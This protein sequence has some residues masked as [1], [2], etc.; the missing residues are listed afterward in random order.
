[1]RITHAD[2]WRNRPSERNSFVS[3]QAHLSFPFLRRKKVKKVLDVACGNGLG[4]SLPLM[5]EG[6]EVH[7][8]DKWKSSV[9]ALEKNSQKEGLRAHARVSNMYEEFPYKTACF[10]ASFCFQAIYHGD[11]SQIESAL[12]EIKRVTKAGGYFFCT[13]I[14]YLIKEEKGRSFFRYTK[15]NGKIGRIYVRQDRDDPFLC[16]NLAKDCEYLVPHY[17]FTKDKLRSTLKKYFKDIHIQKVSREE[18][19]SDLWFVRCRI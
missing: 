7:S 9:D 4:V 13:F 6:Y 12:K 3:N 17:Y 15:K 16:Y 11:I 8:F 1:M 14:P 19:L 5:R 18:K 2:V 10:D